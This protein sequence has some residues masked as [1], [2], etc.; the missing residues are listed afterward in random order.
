MA[1]LRIDPG[2]YD[3]ALGSALG[4]GRMRSMQE[5][6]R[7]SGFVAVINAGMFRADDRM[8]STGYMRDANVVINSFIHPNYGAFL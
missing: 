3:V 8:R 4:T 6:A 5:W 7:H 2:R 1:V